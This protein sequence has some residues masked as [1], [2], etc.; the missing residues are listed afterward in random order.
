MRRALP[1]ALAACLAASASLLVEDALAQS[2]VPIE[3]TWEAPAECPDR[4]QA[5]ERIE[6][7]LGG[8]AEADDAISARASIRRTEA[9]RWTVQLMV[10]RPGAGTG[11]RRI[12]GASCD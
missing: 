12:E 4:S 6:R 11:E 7:L 10:T 2:R 5:L 8:P 9:G 1:A 3:L